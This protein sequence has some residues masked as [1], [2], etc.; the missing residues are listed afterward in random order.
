MNL[1]SSLSGQRFCRL[2]IGTLNSQH[3]GNRSQGQRQDWKPLLSQSR[4]VSNSSRS[5][6]IL[7]SRVFW[8]LPPTVGYGAT[9]GPHASLQNLSAGVR[10]T[11]RP[12]YPVAR[13]HCALISLPNATKPQRAGT[14]RSSLITEQLLQPLRESR[15]ERSGNIQVTRADGGTH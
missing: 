5:S 9:H 14:T 10:A 8:P 6:Y 12:P 2:E 4:P 3:R 7:V 1:I 13:A 15:C 11:A